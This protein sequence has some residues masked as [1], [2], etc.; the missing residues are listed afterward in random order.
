MDLF[1]LFFKKYFF[2][3]RGGA[4]IR[5]MARL[6]WLATLIGVFSL[7]VVASV[8]GGFNRTIRNKLLSVEPHL[9]VSGSPSELEIVQTLELAHDF[10]EIG[11]IY[12]QDVILRTLDGRFSAA[13]ARGMSDQMLES[14]LQRVE[15]L[16]FKTPE[17]SIP[18]LEVPRLEARDVMIGVDLARELNLFEGDELLLIPPETLLAP[19]GEAMKFARVRI[20]KLFSTDFSE[21]DS[22]IILFLYSGTPP[23][24]YS[25]ASA[26]TGLQIRLQDSDAADKIKS[27]LLSALGASKT[28]DVKT[29]GDLNR[30]LFFSLKL[31]RVAMTTFLGLSILITCFSLITVLVMLI[32][33]KRKEIGLLMALGLSELKTKR[34]FLALGLLLSGLGL[35][36]GLGLGVLVS[37]IIDKYPIDVLPDIYYDSALPAEL[38]FVF[39]AG[40]AV[41]CLF[42]AFLAAYL[43]VRLYLK[44]SP[45]ENLRLFSAD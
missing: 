40:V 9:K 38:N 42:I 20:A 4:V 14:F 36:V 18:T 23:Q 16:K 35:F 6:C 5:T 8:M 29:W 44:Y 33:Q 32:S 13:I 41:G 28:F 37:L 7:V 27:Q 21:I 12:E 1:V 11:P 22:R 15:K 45:S 17:H 24:F 25:A 3:K 10:A 34:L 2:S 26:S 19:A 31:E 30:A 43:P 39:I